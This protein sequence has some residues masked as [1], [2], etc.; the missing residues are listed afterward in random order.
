GR[1]NDS[2]RSGA[3]GRGS[4]REGA[5][6]AP[7]RRPP[8]HPA[9]RESEGSAR[10][11]RQRAR[12]DGIHLRR[13]GRGCARRGDPRS[14]PAADHAQSGVRQNDATLIRNARGEA[15]RARR[16]KR[17]KKCFLPFLP[18]LPFLLP[19]DWFTV[20]MAN[21]L[22]AVISSRDVMNEWRRIGA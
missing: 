7:R 22:S 5:G 1:R 16:A 17:A 4:E 8:R 9:Q 2:E 6:R 15:K 3:A 19:A 13:A 12:R 10:T 14:G 21:S 11:A 20:V 18:F